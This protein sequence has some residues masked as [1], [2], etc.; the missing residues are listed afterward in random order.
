VF[1]ASRQTPKLEDQPLSFVRGCSFNMLAA[2]LHN[3]RPFPHPQPE[4]EP[5]CGDR[6]P[7]SRELSKCELDLLGVQELRGEGGGTEPVGEY[8]LF[9]G[10][11]NEKHES[12]KGYLF[13]RESYLQLRWLSLILIDCHT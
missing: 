1:L 2:T 10:M 8:T 6:D 4:G 9:Y 13:I 5:C 3:R 12:G 7:P 11:R